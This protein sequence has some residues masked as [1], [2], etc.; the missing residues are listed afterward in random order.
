MERFFSFHIEN[1]EFNTTLVRRSMKIYIEYFD[2]ERAY[3]MDEEVQPYLNMSE[4]R[5]KEVM[6]R[7]ERHDYSDFFA[8]NALM[9]E[10]VVR[11]QAVR[12]FLAKDLVSGSSEIDSFKSPSTSGYAKTQSEL[13]QRQKSRMVRFYQFH[14]ARTNLDTTDRKA[15]VFALFEKK[16]QRIENNYLFLTASNL[17]MSNERIEN[18]LTLRILKSLAKSLDTHTSF[19][20]PEE[21]FEMRMS[22]EKQFEGVGVVLS[23]GI[24]GVIIAE[25]IKGSPAEQSGQIQ[26]ND[27]LVEVNGVPT[28]SRPFEEVLEMLKKTNSNEIILG[29]KRAE[30][31]NQNFFRVPLLKRA[32]SM[33]EERIQVSYDKTD[34]G[35]IGKISLHSF[36]ESGEGISSEKDIK[37]AIRKLREKGDLVGLVLDL[38]ENS[39][40]FL[41]QAVKVAGLF[42]TNGVVVISKYGKG[43]VHF[44]RNIVAKSFYNGPLVVL[45]SKMSASASEIVAQALQ[46]YGVAL[47]VGDERTFGKGSIQYQTVTD[48]KADMFYK[49]TV[50]R[51]YTASGKSTQIDGVIADIVVPSHYAPYKIGEKYLEYPLSADHVE[52]AFVD[53]LSDLDEKTRKLFEMRYLP[54]TQ[55]VVGFWKKMLPTL[56]QNSASRMAADPTFQAFL[57]KQDQIQARSGSLPPNTVDEQIQVGMEDIQMKEAVNIVKDMIELEAQSDMPR[58]G[59]D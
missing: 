30:A 42:V 28:S 38:R 51:Y 36:Y 19:F 54:F 58:T 41:S 47:V 48:A 15:K 16:V 49:V 57:K 22:L 10:S 21:A 12:S 34:G 11:A 33:K 5:A 25:L 4:K 26:I 17:P 32:I 31:K 59:T 29:F 37:E 52:P 20:S 27:L 7:L 46:D 6:S 43:E 24:D 9:Q 3:L 44:L 55:R 45:T 2:P 13:I 14:K 53:P 56:K 40:G 1:K 39:G 18:L 8:L 23:E 50:G 35:I